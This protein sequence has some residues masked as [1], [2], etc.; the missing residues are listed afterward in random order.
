MKSANSLSQRMIMENVGSTDA[1]ISSSS[2][3]RSV[4]VDLLFSLTDLAEKEPSLDVRGTITRE[5]VLS[6]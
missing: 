2:D 3:A 5:N 1:Q 6:V 4:L